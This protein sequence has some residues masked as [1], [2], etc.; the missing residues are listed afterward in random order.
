MD[1]DKDQ[2]PGNKLAPSEF[3]NQKQVKTDIRKGKVNTDINNFKLDV[4]EEQEETVEEISQ[5]S[6]QTLSQE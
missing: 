2:K 4:V 3:K 1:F 6:N 5:G